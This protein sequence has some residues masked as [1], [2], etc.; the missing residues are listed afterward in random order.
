[1]LVRATSCNQGLL[2]HYAVLYIYDIMTNVPAYLATY[3]DVGLKY[4]VGNSAT[5]FAVYDCLV[6]T[7][8][9]HVVDD[10]LTFG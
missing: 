3:N 4:R 8:I 5:V 2:Y 9:N 6:A 1:M 7:A 10:I